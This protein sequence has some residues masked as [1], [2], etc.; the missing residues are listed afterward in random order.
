[1]LE[2]LRLLLFGRRGK[3]P[4]IK[5]SA[6]E[7]GLFRRRCIVAVICVLLLAG[8][9]VSRMVFLQIYQY[10]LYVMQSEN[11]RIRV[12][13]IAPARGLIYDRN[14]LVLAENRP[15][16]NLMITRE[17]A[18]N[19]DETID[20][21]MQV[22]SL[23]PD[24]RTTLED[25]SRQR[26]RPYEAAL[27]LSD[28]NEWQMARIA[29]NQYRLPGVDIEPQ[30]LRHY[31]DS[32]D[33]AHV[34]G[35]VGRMNANDLKTF[36]GSNYAG[37]HFVGKMGVEREY[38]DVL[39][40]KVGMRRVETNAH[41]RVLGEIDRTPP[42]KGA[43]LTLSIDSRMQKLAM[44]LLNGRRGAV[45]AIQPKTGQII[46]LAS[47]PGFDANKF[48]TG[49]SSKDY[50]QLQDDKDL[51]LYSRATRGEYPPASTVKPYMALA[52]LQNHVISPTDTIYDRGYYQLP[53]QSHRYRNWYRPGN[54]LLNMHKAI[55][56]SNDTY[57]FNLAHL[58]GIDRI[59]DFLSKF[60]YGK[61]TAAD[62]MGARPG[63]LPS[64]EW[65][66]KRFGKSWWSGETLSVGVGQ[67]YFLATPLQMATSL[68][69]IANRG[70]WVRPHLLVGKNDTAFQLPE[71]GSPPDVK[72][73]DPSGWNTI[74]S[75]MEGVANNTA[76]LR[77]R[78]YTMAAK[79]G[80]AQVYTVGQNQHYNAHDI[81]ER[82]RD[83][84]LFTAF[85]PVDNPQIAV[86]VIVE[87][88]GWGAKAAAPIGKKMVDAWMDGSERKDRDVKLP[89]EHNHSAPAPEA[90][91]D[92]VETPPLGDEGGR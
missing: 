75:G 12:E 82:L 74:I 81:A 41:G 13:P 66:R 84:S 2:N 25:R 43:D 64:Q 26:Q 23:P 68:S 83:H 7:I 49:I 71:K 34:L 72:L 86:A 58:L 40:G 92:A 27:L 51:P 78:D 60:G 37:T 1:M 62:V 70:H 29:L 36:S 28:L 50:Q 44:R 22:L 5:D 9:L 76:L 69:V 30:L 46:T 20:R 31:T 42:V 63:V 4:Q 91:D 8:G 77:N 79:T 45:V 89:D 15:T 11:N 16:Y 47:A 85:A 55:A 19:A 3:P 35:Y 90:D 33:M 88:G 6:A 53:G 24:M 32:I 21:I 57:F 17:Q 38:E 87:N 80:T 54:G 14:G 56:L 10:K 39:H 67:G 48:V 52:G 59:H 65:K 73:D 18:D 61:D